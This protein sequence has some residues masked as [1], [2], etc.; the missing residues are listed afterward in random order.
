MAACQLCGRGLGIAARMRGERVCGDCRAQIKRDADAMRADIARQLG[1]ITLTPAQRETI[2]KSFNIFADLFPLQTKYRT[3]YADPDANGIQ[4]PISYISELQEPLPH[5]A[6][7]VFIGELVIKNPRNANEEANI[8]KRDGV[9]ATGQLEYFDF[10]LRDDTGQLGCRIGIRDYLQIGVELAENVPIGAHL[11]VR[12]KFWN[13]IP[14][15][16]V[17]KWRRLDGTA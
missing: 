15:G 10:R 9:I 13:G 4:G 14:Y 17:Y 1:A 2:A 12:A 7:R 16:F 5:G 11:I 3:L 6:E 8:K